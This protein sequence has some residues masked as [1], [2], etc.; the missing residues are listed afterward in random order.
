M[1]KILYLHLEDF[2]CDYK[3]N[4]KIFKINTSIL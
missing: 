4:L 1:I 2:K 3:F